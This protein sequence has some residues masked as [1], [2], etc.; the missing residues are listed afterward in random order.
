MVAVVTAA[1]VMAE[2]TDSL[3]SRKLNQKS[4]K[5]DFGLI[6]IRYTGGVPERY[7][8]NP[9]TSCLICKKLIYRR[10]VE[11]ER[12]HGRSFCGSAC[13]GVFCRIW[14]IRPTIVYVDARIKRVVS[15]SDFINSA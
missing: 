4:P 8:R 11:M 6:E 10:P 7:K 12:N 9:N 3:V 5:G 15:V 2:G 14:K 1:V 13:F